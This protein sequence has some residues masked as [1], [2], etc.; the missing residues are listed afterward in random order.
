MALVHTPPDMEAPA[1]K[2]ARDTGAAA[3]SASTENPTQPAT[4]ASAS[5]ENPTQPAADSDAT[6]PLHAPQQ[7]IALTDADPPPSAQ[8]RD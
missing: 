4:A 6:L 8:P 1:A 5:T 2:K 3:A 7:E